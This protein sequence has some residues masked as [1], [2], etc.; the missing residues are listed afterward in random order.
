M[1]EI[2]ILEDAKPLRRILSYVLREEGHSVTESPDGAASY[3]SGL[4][5]KIDVLITDIDMPRINGFEAILEA[6]KRRPDL[7]IIAISGG[8]PNLVDEYLTACRELGVSHV[9]QK[10]FEPDS[11]V[12]TVRSV[13]AA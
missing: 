12:A 10:P 6:Q 5:G 4:M 9:M 7:K 13:M 11:L 3:D 8:N 2:L 1:A